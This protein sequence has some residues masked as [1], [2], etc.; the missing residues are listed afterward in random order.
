MVDQKFF[1][2]HLFDGDIM[3]L[4]QFQYWGIASEVCFDSVTFFSSPLDS[5]FAITQ[6]KS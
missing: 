2:E 5:I 4:I 6:Q 1:S 3:C